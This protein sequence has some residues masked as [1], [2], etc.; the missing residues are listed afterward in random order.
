MCCSSTLGTRRGLIAQSQKPPLRLDQHRHQKKN[1]ARG[2]RNQ[3]AENPFK[4]WY[5]TD[6]L[7]QEF[8]KSNQ[9]C[10]DRYPLLPLEQP[11]RQ[12]E[13]AAGRLRRRFAGT[14]AQ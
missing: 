14:P 11:R 4:E 7:L 12:K 3:S 6:S 13:S 10:K 8:S 1:A 5:N 2:L 9:M